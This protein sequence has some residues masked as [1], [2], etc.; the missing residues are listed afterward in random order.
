[1]NLK[2][3][4]S[5]LTAAALATGAISVNAFAN[6]KTTIFIAGDSTAC[7]YGTD[8]NYAV[9]RAGWGMY[10]S[11]FIDDDIEVKNY[12]KS[13]RSSKSFAAE[14]NYTQLMSELGEGDYLLIQFGHNDQKKSSDEDLATR[15]TS[16][17]GGI[18]DE[19]S[20]KNSL[21]TSYIK[22]ALDKG[23]TPILLTPIPRYKFN[24]DGSI[25]DS[26]GQYDD[27]VREL[28]EELD[29]DCL[30]VNT[31]I[32]KVYDNHA[33][34]A[35]MMHAIYKDNT[36][37]SDGLDTTHLNHLGGRAVAALVASELSFVDTDKTLV[38]KAP[39]DYL[40]ITRA[41]F[42][43][44]LVRLMGAEK[45]GEAFADVTDEAYSKALTTAKTIGLAKGD[46]N[47]NFMPN[48]ALTDEE[49]KILVQRFCSINNISDA[50]CNDIIASLTYETTIENS[51]MAYNKLYS[52]LN[53]QSEGA[54][55]TDDQIEKVE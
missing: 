15:Y 10:L 48:R 38:V 5:T 50:D 28:A 23:A 14:D 42:A 13:G 44:E 46:G 52:A 18:N 9:P 37:G 49:L 11:S 16:P 12:A 19:G 47:N 21:Y 27:D 22:P 7:N 45:D 2:K 1:M 31:D 54:A 32:S 4:M 20:F 43:A 39:E 25:A 30:D 34:D 8:D 29:I 26:H 6:D 51:Y 41:D 36:K 53:G 24:E 3:F 55:Q 35:V 40:T 17:E 33:D